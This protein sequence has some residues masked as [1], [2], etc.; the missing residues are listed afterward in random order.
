[1]AWGPL[2]AVLVLPVAL[3]LHNRLATTRRGRQPV[4]GALSAVLG[5]ATVPLPIGG[6]AVAVA[7]SRRGAYLPGRGGRQHPIVDA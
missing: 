7:V 6:H 2:A 4:A 3:L 5:A 1:M